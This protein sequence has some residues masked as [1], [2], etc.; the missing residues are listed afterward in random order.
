MKG[1]LKLFRLPPTLSYRSRFLVPSKLPSG[2]IIIRLQIPTGSLPPYYID[3]GF[4]R[5]LNPSREG[6]LTHSQPKNAKNKLFEQ[7]LRQKTMVGSDKK[8]RSETTK[9]RGRKRQK[10]VVGND[11]KPWSE[12][13]KN[14]G[15]K[16][17]KTAVG[18]DK[19]NMLF[20]RILGHF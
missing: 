13:T 6:S 11:K 16:R 15:R 18:S 12:T 8:P 5:R 14:R 17:Q 3:S 2:G 4:W 10:T 7:L 19:K 9:N 20:E 1:W